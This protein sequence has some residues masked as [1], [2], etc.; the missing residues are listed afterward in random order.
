MP[1]SS[2]GGQPPDALPGDSRKVLRQMLEPEE[3]VV[4]VVDGIGA[5]L[6][7]TDRRLILVREGV[8]YRPKSGVQTWPLDR[9]LRVR[10][11]PVRHGTGR[12]V[13]DREARAT[14]VFVAADRWPQAEALIGDVNRAISGSE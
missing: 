1:K 3:R 2:P 8:A 14:S 13:V 11:T 12:L 5:S 6:V 10:H 7:L 9:T 4:R